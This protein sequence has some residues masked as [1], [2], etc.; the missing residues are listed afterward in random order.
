MQEKVEDRWCHVLEYPGHDR[1]WVD[2]ERN[3][4]LMMQEMFNPNTGALLQRIEL[5]GYREVKPGIWAPREF[6]NIAFD[7]SG[8]KGDH[9]KLTDVVIKA[10][11]GGRF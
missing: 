8:Q 3:G 5:K 7:G 11:I 1:L 6:R 2:V 9:H 10:P 4:A